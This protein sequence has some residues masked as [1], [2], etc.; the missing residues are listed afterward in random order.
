MLVMEP[1]GIISVKG[2]YSQEDFNK[3][4]ELLN[5]N[6]EGLADYISQIIKENPFCKEADL[7]RLTGR[8]TAYIRWILPYLT[9]RDKT[10]AEN[11]EGQLFYLNFRTIR[12]LLVRG[13]ITHDEFMYAK[14]H[15]KLDI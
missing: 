8:P 4:N 10:L 14:E 9:A 12:T 6:K 5:S 3:I 2:V 15:M 11:D 1:L 7:P 13:E